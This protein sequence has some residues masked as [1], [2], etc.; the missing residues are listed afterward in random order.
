[1]SPTTL[2]ARTRDLAVGVLALALVV[3][4]VRPS[5]EHALAVSAEFD[6]AGLNV[7]VND[8]VRIR[9]VPVGHIVAIDTSGDRGAT[10]HLELSD[11]VEVAADSGARIVPKTLFGDK[12]VELDGAR[13]GEPVLAAGDVIPRER[14]R[15]VSELEEV[16]D[17]LGGL[18]EEV[19]LAALGATVDVYAEAMGDGEDLARAMRGLGAMAE[20]ASE[21]RDAFRGILATA[22]PVADTFA[23]RAGDLESLTRDLSKVAGTLADEH[24]SFATALSSN[25]DL[26]ERATTLVTDDRLAALTDDGLTVLDIVTDHPGAVEEYLGGVPDYLEGVIDAVF[27]T[28]LYALVPDMLVALPHVAG[29]EALQRGDAERG[30][31]PGPHVVIDAGD[32]DPPEVPPDGEGEE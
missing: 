27:L 28:T 8:E 11:D 22:P 26:L 21:E 18:L 7:R 24:E 30:S 4:V 1:M 14:T 25:A 3:L 31:G 19:D 17:R 16:L 13:E 6:R 29:Y 5:G 12:F 32:Q 15:P 10:Y 9:G 20:L 23:R 2:A